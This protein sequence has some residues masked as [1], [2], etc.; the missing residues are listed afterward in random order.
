V[1]AG[2]FVVDA[3]W[4]YLKP[5]APRIILPFPFYTNHIRGRY[6]ELF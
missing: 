4:F 6:I 2:I 5:I 3:T 1:V